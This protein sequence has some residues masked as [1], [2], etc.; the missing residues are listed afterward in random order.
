MIKQRLIAVIVVRDGRVVQS[1][2]FK[3]DHV[4]HSDAIHAVESFS[5]WDVDEI[6]MLNVSKDRTSREV[7]VDVV[8]RVSKVCF[9]PLTAGGFVDDEGYAAQLIKSGADKLILNTVFFNSPGVGKAIADRFGRQCL[10]AS[11]DV[12]PINNSERVVYVD[13]GTVSTGKKLEDWI[14]HCESNGAGEIFINNIEHDGDRRG[15][16][17]VS[18]LKAVDKTTLPIIAFGGA[19]QDKHFAEGLEAGASAVAAANIFHYK[20]MATKQVKRYLKRKGFN[21]REQ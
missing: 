14:V 5:R 18:I 3:H 13:R 11:I 19:F 8:E 1:E 4:I 20:E 2:K 17:I 10:V 7:F 12:R 21:V 16:D 9:V 6:V 15:Y